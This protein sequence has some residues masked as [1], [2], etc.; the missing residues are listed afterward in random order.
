MSESKTTICNFF[1][2]FSSSWKVSFPDHI[3]IFYLQENGNVACQMGGGTKIL[4]K[5]RPGIKDIFSGYCKDKN[6]QLF[7]NTGKNGGPL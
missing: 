4:V 5:S 3:R 2:Y 7:S 6:F 1:F